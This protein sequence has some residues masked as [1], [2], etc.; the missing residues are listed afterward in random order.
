MHSAFL[1]KDGIMPMS[2]VEAERYVP[3]RIA[4]EERNVHVPPVLAR[5][6]FIALAYMSY[7]EKS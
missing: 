7:V 2:G 3:G 6:V 4:G 1:G 5:Q